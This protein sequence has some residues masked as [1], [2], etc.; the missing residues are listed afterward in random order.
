MARRFDAIGAGLL[1]AI[2]ALAAVA[3]WAALHFGWFRS[4]WELAGV[5]VVCAAFLAFGLPTQSA[6]P[7]T[8]AKSRWATRLDLHR[9]NIAERPQPESVDQGVYLGTFEDRDPRGALTLRYREGKHLLSF[10]TPGANKSTG[11]V[12]P[13]FQHLRRSVIVIDPKGELAAI[14]ARKRED[15]GRVIVLNPFDLFDKLPR[16]KS[17]G[18]NPLLQLDPA[19]HDFAGDAY[20]IADALIDKGGGGNSKFFENSAENLAIAL[21]MWERFSK[22]DKAS[23]DNLRA[24]VSAPTEFKETGKKLPNGEP[25]KELSGGFLFTLQQMASCEHAAIANVSGRIFARLTGK[26]EAK[27]V[28]DVIDTFMAS[29]RFLD[30]PRIGA[31]MWAGGAIDF[32]ALHRDITTI[33]LILPA[34]ELVAN[35]KWLRLFINLALR[36]LYKNPPTSPTLPPRAFHA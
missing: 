16:L 3:G 14:T 7:P 10:G 27:S 23:L 12:V 6:P 33:Y 11:L 31:D 26:G 34:D 8:V 21:V 22:R 28:E 35:A 29:T 2:A 32:G 18:W 36:K 9:Y 30:D 19:S 17:A 13:N 20:C 1:A 15:M 25:E 24:L 5:V 4:P